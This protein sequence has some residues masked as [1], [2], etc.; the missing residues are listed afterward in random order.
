M[1]KIQGTE[2]EAIVGYC[3]PSATKEMRYHRLSSSFSFPHF[4]LD[5]Q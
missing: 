5:S 3:E 4:T 2:G 1:L